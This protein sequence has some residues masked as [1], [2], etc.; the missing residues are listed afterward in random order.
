[1][2]DGKKAKNMIS[3]FIQK[4]N[5]DWKNEKNKKIDNRTVRNLMDFKISTKHLCMYFNLKYTKIISNFWI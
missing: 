3:K 5:F 1:V 2:Y 4:R